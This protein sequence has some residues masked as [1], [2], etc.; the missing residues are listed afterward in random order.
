LA[1]E[2]LKLLL[3][4]LP[5]GSIF[6]VVQFDSEFKKIFH[7]S[8]E[9]NDA[10]LKIAMQ[11]MGSFTSKTKEIDIL[12]PLTD[13][14]SKARHHDLPLSVFLLTAGNVSNEDQVVD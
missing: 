14:F 12:S 8:V 3:H 9:Y 4:S 7:E 10:N 5:T 6:N 13:I 11:K 2:A 1:I